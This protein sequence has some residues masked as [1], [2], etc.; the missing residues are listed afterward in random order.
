MGLKR[1]SSLLDIIFLIIIIYIY[2]YIYIYIY[3]YHF[4]WGLSQMEGEPKPPYPLLNKK[5]REIVIDCV[6]HWH[7]P[8]GRSSS[9]QASGLATD[10]WRKILRKLRPNTRPAPARWQGGIPFSAAADR[11][12]RQALTSGT[13]PKP[14]LSQ[15]ST[16]ALASS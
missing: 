14:M 10:H 9:S 1:N 16:C 5:V 15:Q 13:K 6:P 3:Y 4:S 2:M 11:V 12:S 8:F 7:G